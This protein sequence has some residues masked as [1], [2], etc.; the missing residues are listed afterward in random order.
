MFC[1]ECR[2][3]KKN[4]VI[5]F[6]GD[7]ISCK[8][9]LL[10]KCFCFAHKSHWWEEDRR[11]STVIGSLCIARLA[12]LKKRDI[13]TLDRYAHIIAETEQHFQLD[14][15]KAVISAARV[16]HAWIKVTALPFDRSRISVSLAEALY[17]LQFA[18]CMLNCW[19]KEWMLKRLCYIN[20]QVTGFDDYYYY[21][22]SVLYFTQLNASIKKTKSSCEIIPTLLKKKML[23]WS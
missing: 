21:F 1:P 23:F 10:Y 8:Y 18:W 15:F 6:V 17:L 19:A 4:Y 9:W 12:E 11:K 14:S 5:A 7:K 16:C 20:Y 3:K 2:T 13:Y 22:Y